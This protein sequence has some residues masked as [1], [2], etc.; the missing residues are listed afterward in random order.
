MF[1]NTIGSREA[2]AHLP[3]LLDRV[4][5]GER[6]TITRRGVAVAVLTPPLVMGKTNVQEAIRTILESRKRLHLG[7]ISL[8]DMR[9]EGRR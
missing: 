8:R 4:A 6:I 3:A 2:R 1:S 7:G 9:E 5:T